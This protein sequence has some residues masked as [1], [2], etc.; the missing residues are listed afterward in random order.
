MSPSVTIIYEI[1]Y[2]IFYFG[3]LFS[4]STFL[5]YFPKPSI[6][7]RFLFFIVL[8]SGFFVPYSLK[9]LRIRLTGRHYISLALF[10]A[11]LYILLSQYYYSNLLK[12]KKF[13]SFLQVKPTEQH[14][15]VPKP[16]DVYRII[17]LGGSTT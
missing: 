1:I 15:L 7:A 2:T 17:C 8:F 5:E 4:K 16:K 12:E 9:L 3:L 13:H 14:A 6:I 10:L 11:L